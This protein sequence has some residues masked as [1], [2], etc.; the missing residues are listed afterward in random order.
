MMTPEIG[1]EAEVELTVAPADT[2]ARLYD[3]VPSRQYFNCSFFGQRVR[4]LD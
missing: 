2:A 4:C 1:A 3:L